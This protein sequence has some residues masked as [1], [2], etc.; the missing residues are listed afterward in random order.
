M[1]GNKRLH[2]C[3]E[4]IRTEPVG[5]RIGTEFDGPEDA[6][7]GRDEEVIHGSATRSILPVSEQGMG[8]RPICSAP[9]VVKC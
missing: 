9:A 4:R 8:L 6:L 1:D 2:R 3:D 7:N 5:C